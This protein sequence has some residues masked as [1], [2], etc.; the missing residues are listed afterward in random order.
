MLAMPWLIRVV[1]GDEYESAVTAARIVLLAA[2]LQLVFGWTKSFPVTIG[3]PGLRI[4]AHGIETAVLLP[5]VALLGAE[6]EVTGAAVAILVAS[7]VFVAT[8]TVLLLRVRAE[9]AAHAPREPA[10]AP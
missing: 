3:R 9:V 6:W 1:F 4:V 10:L 7:A 2:A 8:W 5:L